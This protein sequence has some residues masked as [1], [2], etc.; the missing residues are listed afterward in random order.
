M[1]LQ[2][3]H[4]YL[5]NTEQRQSDQ[6][7]VVSPNV[8]YLPDHPLKFGSIMDR[9]MDTSF[10]QI[11]TTTIL[12]NACDTCLRG[13]GAGGA[14]WDGAGG[15]GQG[16]LLNAS[17]IDINSFYLPK[18]VTR[19]SCLRLMNCNTPGVF[20]RLNMIRWVF[21]GGQGL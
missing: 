6:L 2:P 20:I 8:L 4:H 3:I 21:V 19:M 16:E 5:T 12:I 10:M 14:G 15:R 11:N 18:F 1:D 9:E 7:G 13:V 17:K